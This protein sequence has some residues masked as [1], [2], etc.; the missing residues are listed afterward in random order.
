MQ[1]V[2]E[3]VVEDVWQGSA[4]WAQHLEGAGCLLRNTLHYGGKSLG[5]AMPQFLLM[6][7]DAQQI[8]LAPVVILRC[9]LP[10]WD[11]RFLSYKCKKKKIVF[12]TF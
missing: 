1:S 4:L 2:Q 3:G 7:I 5:L 12:A 11:L 8:A 10:Q 6:R 9:V